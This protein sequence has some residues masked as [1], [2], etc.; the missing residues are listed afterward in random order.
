MNE[1]MLWNCPVER[2]AAI[3]ALHAAQSMNVA[4]KHPLWQSTVPLLQ[5]AASVADL[6]GT[7][8]LLAAGADPNQIGANG[9][10]ALGMAVWRDDLFVAEALITAR[11]FAPRGVRRATSR[12]S[13][14]RAS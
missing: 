13:R 11:A 10:T 14:W 4:Q 9:E 5:F 8:A 6:C 12:T 3:N 2:D 7:H 1:A